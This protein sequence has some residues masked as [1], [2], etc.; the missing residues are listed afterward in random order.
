MNSA[1]VLQFWRK[2]DHA[3]GG[4]KPVGRSG[5]AAVCL[6][7]AEGSSLLIT[8]GKDKDNNVLDDIWV[9]DLQSDR[10]KEVNLCVCLRVC[11]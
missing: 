7:S 8:G 10:W 9:L 3:Q 1:C 5:H 2:L 4:P 11:V 6:E